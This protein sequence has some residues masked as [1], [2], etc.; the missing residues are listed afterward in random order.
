MSARLLEFLDI[1]ARAK[2]TDAIV[3]AIDTSF[4]AD[5]SR[6]TQNEIQHR[7]RLCLDLVATMRNDA[8]WSWSRIHDTLPEALRAKLDGS[9]WVPPTRSSWRADARSGLILPP[10]A[11]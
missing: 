5:R 1:D 8:R 9:D 2:A 6:Q 11:R 3:N 7:F 4:A 10:G